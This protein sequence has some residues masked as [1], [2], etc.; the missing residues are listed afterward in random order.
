MRTLSKGNLGEFQK[1]FDA[2]S[3]RPRVILLVSPT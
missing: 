2:E 1:A 3:D